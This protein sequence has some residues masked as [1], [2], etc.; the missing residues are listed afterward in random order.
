M[1]A[2]AHPPTEQPTAATARIVGDYPH[3]IREVTHAWIPL[4]DGTRLACRYWLPEDAE[5][6]P[7]PAILEYIPYRKRDGTAARDEAMHP[8]FAGHGYA[9]IRVDMRGSGESDGLL[10]DEYL[11]QEQDDALEV[12][13]W[14]AA[15]PWCTGRVGMM[16]KSWGGFNGLQVA[17]RR[18]PALACIITVYSTDDRYADDI[19]YMGGCLLAENPIWAFT[20]FGQCARP[21]DPLLV[22]EGW[23]ETWQARLDAV[24]PWIL[25]WLRHQRRDAFWRHGSVCEDYA[26]IQCPVYAI[27]GWADPYTNPVLR[28]LA[29]LKVP[30]KALVGPWGHQYPHQ[31]WPG[32]AAGFL[33]DALRW[34]DHWL[35]DVDT[36]IMDEPRYRV[37][38][39]ASAPPKAHHDVRP[40]HWVAEPGWPSAHVQPRRLALDADGLADTPGPERPL[41]VASPQSTGSCSLIWGNDGAGSPECPLDQ[42]A[43]DARSLCFDSPPLGETLAILGAPVAEL[44]L[45]ADRPEALVAVRLCEVLPDGASARV[46]YGVLNLTHRNGHEEVAPLE[47]GRRYRVRV[48]LNDV[49]HA[50]AAGSRIRL[51]VATAQWPIVWPS[52]RPV[53][54]TV[55]AGTSALE[56]PVR[57]PRP[58][59]AALAPLPAPETSPLQPRT[60]LRVAPP[61][62]LR[63]ERDVAGNSVTMVHREGGGRTR[64]ERDG[65]EFGSEVRRR[66]SVRDD[67]P[68]SARIELEGVEEFGRA[69]GLEVRIETTTLMTCDE[70]DFQVQARLDVYEGGRPVHSRSWLERVPRDGV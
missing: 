39:Q 11:K 65:W 28:L 8:Y 32:P 57:P 44:E 43:D 63:L 25:E 36:G 27:G 38:M 45:A 62:T 20:M 46:S 18:P 61:P 35:K 68:T 24:R 2:D 4:A 19:H 67:D 16:G 64:I 49:A 12:I 53:T 22:G 50:F 34:W 60:A 17:A 29:H 58:E 66:L 9:A 52:P 7:V 15:Q 37:W 55:V 3:P 42:R 21:P 70:R 40:G 56:L 1:T 33:Q 47:P 6:S 5:T 41:A 23:R 48:Q 51:A 31:A 54:L 69:G 30:A 10:L 14:I 26:A 13:A 59:D